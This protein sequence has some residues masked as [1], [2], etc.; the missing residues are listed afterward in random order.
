M[1][2]DTLDVNLGYVVEAMK[3]V[4]EK[5][6]VRKVVTFG[7]QWSYKENDKVLASYSI[8]KH[9]LKR[10]TQLLNE[11]GINAFHFCVPTSKTEKALS[12]SNYLG[13]VKQNLPL[14]ET[15][16]AE[17]DEIT[18]IIVKE[19]LNPSSENHL[20]RFE[21]EDNTAWSMLTTDIE[22][23]SLDE[24]IEQ[25]TLEDFFENDKLYE[26]ANELYVN[27]VKKELLEDKEITLEIKSKIV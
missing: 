9:L 24:K 14:E 12:I 23:D 8:A 1:I 5:G 18:E 3:K 10:F 20:Y 19:L 21:S 17:P 16:W 2:S 26:I 4:L 7:S 11:K 25:L 13:G 27:L 6:N 15:K 22:M